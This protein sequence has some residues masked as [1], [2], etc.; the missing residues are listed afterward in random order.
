M[1]TPTKQTANQRH[2]GTDNDAYRA[3]RHQLQAFIARRVESTQTAEDLTQEVLLRLVRSNAD[4]LADP[5]AWLYRVARNVIIDHYRTR[6]PASAR[7]EASELSDSVDP[8]A[9]D[10]ALARQELAQCLR[11]LIDQLDEPY[12]SA[13]TAVDLDGRTHA[14]LAAHTGLSVPGMKS[15]V[16]RARRQLRHLL[17]D[18]CDVQTS[19]DGTVI[20]YTAPPSCLASTDCT[21]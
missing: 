7:V 1:T 16:Q 20:D 14:S 5:A 17:T 8:F 4:E 13:I 9:D 15:R 11:A 3:L 6:R 12:R 10:P 21:S 19:A 18:C 2:A